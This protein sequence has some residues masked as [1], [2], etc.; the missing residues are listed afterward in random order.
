MAGGAAAGA[1]PM[2][3]RILVV[4]AG[5]ATVAFTVPAEA[6]APYGELRKPC[7][8]TFLTEPC[9]G[10]Y[11]ACGPLEAPEEDHCRRGQ[12]VW[13]HG[14]AFFLQPGFGYN[15]TIVVH[16]DHALPYSY[17]CDYQDG[18]PTDDCAEDGVMPRQGVPF[19]FR[20]T[21]EG[22]GVWGCTLWHA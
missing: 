22:V 4:L 17:T 5:L 18:L 16:L 6:H 20:C 8:T 11:A 7:S 9:E 12:H 19:R 15:G 10:R 21:A 13:L 14:L 1:M 2:Q 3:R